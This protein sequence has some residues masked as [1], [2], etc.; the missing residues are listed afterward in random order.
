M[1]NKSPAKRG[2][3]T[4]NKGAKLD[5]GNSLRAADLGHRGGNTPAVHLKG[6]P[7]K[8]LGLCAMALRLHNNQNLLMWWAAP[9]FSLRRRGHSPLLMAF[10]ERGK[11]QLCIAISP[12]VPS[13]GGA[14]HH[15]AFGD[16]RRLRRCRETDCVA[17]H[18][19]LELRNV[20]KNYPFERSRRIS[21]DPAEF[22]PQ[23]PFT[24]ELRR[25]AER[26]SGLVP[27]RNSNGAPLSKAVELR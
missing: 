15:F 13:P 25:R 26:S 21:G 19:G 7:A 9:E 12:P 16:L 1:E 17:G 2:L 20:G 3:R 14:A 18:G 4:D 24:F 5:G 22:R 27:A 8:A 11:K 6:R 10:G 23:R